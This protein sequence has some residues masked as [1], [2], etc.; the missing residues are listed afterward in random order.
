MKRRRALNDLEND[1]RDHL[2]RETQE[3]IERGMTPDAARLAALRKFGNVTRAMEE[4][5][6]VWQRQWVEQLL[7]DMRYALRF[8]S[9]NPRFTAAVV[10]TLALGIGMNTAL[11]SVVNTVLLKPFAY[12][13][14]ARIVMFQTTFRRA[15]RTGSAAPA[16]FNWWRQ[17]T[18]AFEDV[19]AYAFNFANFD[20]RIVPGADPH[21]AGER[22]L[23]PAVRSQRGDRPHL[24]SPG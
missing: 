12:R 5:R 13:D 17:Q 11:F 20:W 3:N 1:I 21:Y 4:T 22:R 8:L 10:L 14:A 9:R 6:G 7:Q 24:H 19:S 15:P 16:E 23:L 2:E 18:A